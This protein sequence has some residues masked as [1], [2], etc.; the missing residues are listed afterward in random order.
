MNT[1]PFVSEK[2]QL[3]EWL[4]AQE[5]ADEALPGLPATK[6]GVNKF[7]DTANWST[8]PA[9][10]RARSG[11]GG[12]LE[13]HYRL[14]PTL[15]QV[16]YVQRHMVVGSEPVDQRPEPE[17]AASAS[18]TERARRERDARLAVVAAFET[19][20]KGLSISVQ[21]SMF[22]FCDRWNMNMIQADAWVKDILPQISQRSVFRWR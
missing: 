5:I 11:V 6:R 16:T 8:N 7:A 9:L 14:F 1:V 15:A 18:L 22:I 4:T 10:C 12:G 21:A 17:P 3:K 13:Y 20:S 19:F 2:R